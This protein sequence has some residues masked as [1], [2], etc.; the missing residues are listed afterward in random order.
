MKRQTYTRN[1]HLKAIHAAKRSKGLTDEEYRGIVQ[2]YSGTT[3][4]GKVHDMAVLYQIRQHLQMM[5]GGKT[6]R[7]HS[8]PMRKARVLWNLLRD[9]GVVHS[10]G[11]EAFNAY[12]K[13]IT[14]KESPRLVSNAEAANVIESLKAWCDRCEV[15]YEQ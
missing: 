13:R 14:K 5:R 6:T 12:V 11:D 15:E 2:R 1:D 4:C 7:Q 3:S 9:A 8:A 10:Q